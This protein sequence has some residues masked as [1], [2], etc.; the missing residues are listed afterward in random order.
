MDNMVRRHF[1]LPASL[2]KEFEQRAGERRQSERVAELIG[3]WLRRERLR[4]AIGRFAGS[5]SAESHPEWATDADVIAWAHDIRGD[6]ERD[7]ARRAE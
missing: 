3:D 6:W 5:I 4:E 1:R 2:A 7:A